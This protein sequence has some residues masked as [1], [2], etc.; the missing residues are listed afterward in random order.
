VKRLSKVRIVTD[1]TADIPLELREKLG[2]EMVSLKVSFGNDTYIDGVSLTP[3]EFYDKLVASTTL[4][5]TSQPSPLDF[6]QKYESLASDDPN[7]KVEIISIHLSSVLSGTYQSAVIA[8]SSIEDD[9]NDR[10]SITIIDAKSASYGTGGQ[11]I[12]AAEAA[13]AGKSK[14]EI[15]EIIDKTKC[16]IYFL[17]DTLEYL[18]KGGRLGKGSAM[19]GSLLNIKP[20]LTIDNDGYVAPIDKVRGQ[21]KAMARIVEL[22]KESDCGK[23][24]H[25]KLAHVRNPEGAETLKQ[26]I[27]AEFDIVTCAEWT[28]GAVIGTYTGPGTVAAF[29]SPA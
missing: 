27:A 13:A 17:V 7:E 3:E 26:M 4:P 12:A 25:I 22:M 10:V 11:V 18:H 1:S 20:I 24:V 9:G 15:L 2:I 23:A 14:E 29:I 16:D 28:I 21:K 6:Q 8:K 5:I 19:I